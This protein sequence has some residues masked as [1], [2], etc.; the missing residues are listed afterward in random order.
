MNDDESFLTSSF[1][2]TMRMWMVE[3]KLMCNQH[4]LGE[5]L[6]LHMFVGTINNGTSVEGYVKN[7]LLETRSLPSRH[8]EIV[9]EMIRRGMN[10]KSP[11]PYYQY[12]N[13]TRSIDREK[14]RN[15]LK[16]RCT[17]CQL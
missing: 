17:K 6:E 4:L 14:A 3:P 16:M 9:S 1:G 10:H 15:D 2:V 7:N 5:H 12:D 8:N 13:D 11:L